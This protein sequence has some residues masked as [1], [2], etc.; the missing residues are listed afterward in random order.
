MGTMPPDF[1]FVLINFRLQSS[2]CIC[3]PAV[4]TVNEVKGAQLTVSNSLRP[5]GLYSPWNSAGR[6]TGVV[7][8][9]LLQGIFPTQGLNP[10]LLHCRRIFYQLSH[11]ESPSMVNTLLK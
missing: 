2:V 10:G 5:R 9:S 8:L 11:K 1:P 3:V 6:N 7:S 4:C